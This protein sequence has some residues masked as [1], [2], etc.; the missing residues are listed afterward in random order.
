MQHDPGLH[1]HEPLDHANQ[2]RNPDIPFPISFVYGD[3]DWMDSR[4]SREIVKANKFFAS[5]LSQLHVLP[6]AG[7][8]LF[9]NNPEGFVTLVV[10]DLLG[11]IKDQFQ[12]N[13]Y[14]VMYADPVTEQ[15]INH[16]DETDQPQE[17]R[18][19]SASEMHEKQEEDD[20]FAFDYEDGDDKELEKIHEDLLIRKE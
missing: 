12:T 2:L 17:T 9:M 18:F 3:K 16:Y 1:A 10:G 4:G 19:K 15:L 13:P 5:G 7:H 6:N 11:T 14:T 8:Q 20:S